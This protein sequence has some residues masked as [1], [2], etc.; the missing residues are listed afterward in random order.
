MSENAQEDATEP[1]LLLANQANRSR[2]ARA[3]ATL[4]VAL[5]GLVGLGWLERRSVRHSFTVLGHADFRWVPLA[6]FAESVSMVTLARLQRRLLRAGGVRPNINSMLRI[7]YASN[8]ISVSIPIAGSPMSAAFS[9]RSF[10][11]L[12]AD[13]SLAGW[14]LAMSGVISTVALALI[15]AVG[16]MVSGNDLAAVIGVLGVLATVVPVL[17]CVIAVRN[18]RLRTRL[19]L[20]GARCLRLAQR[21]I[22]RPQSDPR[23]LIDSAITRLAGLHLRGRSWAFVFFLAVVNWLA[24][25]ACL[26]VAIVAVGS[27]VPWSAL[28][29]AWGVGVAAGSFGLTPGGLGIVEP[30]LA[31]ALVAAGVLAPEALAAVLVYRLISF[32]LVDAFGWTLYLAT[33]KRRPPRPPAVGLIC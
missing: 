5:A 11:R 8:S 6:I 33:R 32:W 1:E 23:E 21:V 17:G 7:I 22:H 30:A 9:F 20:V 15:L 16:A 2:R 31:A 18:A 14:V 19:T 10:A 13:G 4:A 25:I 26:A 28:I 29:L 3:L 24:N 27:P 12:G